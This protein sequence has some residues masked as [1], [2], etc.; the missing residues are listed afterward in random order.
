MA[1]FDYDQERELFSLLDDQQAEIRL[2][3]HLLQATRE[4]LESPELAAQAHRQVLEQMLTDLDRRIAQRAL[5]I[6]R[7]DTRHDAA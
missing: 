2:R 6:A 7:C 1:N 5:L 4:T 3:R